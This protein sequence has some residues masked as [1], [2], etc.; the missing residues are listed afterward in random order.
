MCYGLCLPRESVGKKDRELWVSQSASIFWIYWILWQVGIGPLLVTGSEKE[1]WFQTWWKPYLVLAWRHGLFFKPISYPRK[2]WLGQGVETENLFHCFPLFFHYNPFLWN[3]K[4]VI[5]NCCFSCM[6]FK[7]L[8]F[9]RFLFVVTCKLGNV[10]SVPSK[11][12]L[13]QNIQSNLDFA[14]PWK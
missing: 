3:T 4:L 9:I 10:H 14:Q 5:H 8:C 2:E 6:I 7:D 13:S 1:I 11:K 12:L